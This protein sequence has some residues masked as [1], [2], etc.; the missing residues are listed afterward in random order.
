MD[1]TVFDLV[2]KY[3]W[4]LAP[5]LIV[6]FYKAILRIFFGTV[7]V[8]KDEIGI[9]NKKWVLF[10]KNRTL[11]DGAIVALN[12]EAG[13]QADTLAPGIHFGLWA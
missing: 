12:S 3:G 4:M 6:V 9:L 2:A 13:L 1:P 8:S 10:G 5:V 11:P 7:I